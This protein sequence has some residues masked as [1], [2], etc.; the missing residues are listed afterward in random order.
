MAKPKPHP[1]P[2]ARTILYLAPLIIVFAGFLAYQNSFTGPFIFD[3]KAGITGNESIK[4]IGTA[5]RLNFSQRPI[6]YLSLA[7]NYA[8]GGL[9]PWP[10]HLLNLV[11]HIL[12]GL[13]LYGIVRRTLLLPPFRERFEGAA[14][15]LG[16]VSSLIWLVH[17]L[18][19]AAVTYVIQRTESLMG[20][21]Y[22]ITLY[23][24]L[25]GATAEKSARYGWYAASVAACAL[26]MGSKEVMVTAPLIILLYDRVF[27]AP[28]WRNLL[29][30]RWWFYAGLAASWLILAGPLTYAF[31]DSS[32]ATAQT[33]GQTPATAVP[34]SAGP[35]AGF[36]MPNLTPREYALT[37]TK[38]IFI[39]AGLALWP[40][41]LCLDYGPASRDTPTPS[42]WPVSTSFDGEIMFFVIVLAI[43]LA[44]TIWALFRKPWLGF[45]GAWFFVI[46]APSSSIMPINDLVFEHRMYLSLAAL[47]VLFVVGG[48]ALLREVK[49]LQQQPFL[50]YLELGLAGLIILVLTWRTWDRNHDYRTEVS[51]WQDTVDKA[52]TNFRA[53]QNLG[54]ELAKQGKLDEAANYLTKAVKLRPVDPVSQADLGVVRKNQGRFVEAYE[55]LYTAVLFE[56]NQATALDQL[57]LV[58]FQLNKLDKAESFIQRSLSQAKRP[59]T[60]L[61]LGMVQAARKKFPEAIMNLSIAVKQNPNDADAAYLLGF[62]YRRAGQPEKALVYLSRAKELQPPSCKILRSLGYAHEQ[63]K[64]L[65]EAASCYRASLSLNPRDAEDYFWLAGVY[66]ELGQKERSSRYLQDGRSLNPNWP[67]LANKEARL[68]AASKNHLDRGG[69]L[70]V[71]LAKRVCLATE[72]KDPRY[73]DTLA[74]AYAETGDFKEAIKTAQQAS[75]L[76]ASN[77]E[78]QAKIREHLELYEKGKPLRE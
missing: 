70:A 14:P 11:I 73:L 49:E 36:G 15:F 32:P 66:Q 6:L 12:A 42:G 8:L 47:A 3:D 76:A 45:L 24:F 37:Q 35:S 31:Q 48:H 61:H 4:D 71:M 25:R 63:M 56:P 50:P 46:L 57:G 26:G 58:C 19:T 13:A 52:P 22:L 29:G 9:E 55:H 62:T 5:L 16:L 64:Q 20:M 77:P 23:C 38:V 51:I 68:L 72:Y 59:S 1:V 78:L 53:N 30:Q 67:Q 74:A 75:E 7:I 28:S 40:N 27:I 43:F 10:Y 65:K 34:P 21:F 60:Y 39:Y 17:P 44:G 18:Q 2:P 69:A 54:A 33:A 41:S